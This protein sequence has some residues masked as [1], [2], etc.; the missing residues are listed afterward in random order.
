M[1][2]KSLLVKIFGHPAT[3]IHHDLTVLD[4]WLWI[5]NYLPKTNNKEALIDIGCG[6]GAFTIGA[7]LRG[8]QALGLSWDDR[9]QKVATERA[10]ICHAST[11]TFEIQ[12]VRFLHERKDLFGK[13][14][15]AIC[16][17]NIEHILDDKKLLKDIVTCLKPGGCL[18]LTA[19]Y[20]HLKAISDGDNGP[21]SKLEDGGHVRRGYTKT[22]LQ[23]LSES[24]D[25]KIEQ[26]SF[27]T[28]FFSQKITRLYR[29]LSKIHP[30]LSWLVVVPLRILPLIFDKMITKIFKWPALSICIEAYKPR[31]DLIH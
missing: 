1:I 14:E 12:D 18:L 28:G 25:L 13:F 16:S 8:Y 21:W 19:P 26:I 30:L 6:T 7:S 24:V 3:L 17:E 5:K 2:D 23:E 20:Y 15:V 31:F 27:C 22:M 4:R 29:V 9:N 10:K 11:A